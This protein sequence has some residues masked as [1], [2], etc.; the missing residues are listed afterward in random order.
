[1]KWIIRNAEI[2]LWPKC[3]MNFGIIRFIHTLEIRNIFAIAKE[4]II[5]AEIHRARKED[6]NGRNQDAERISGHSD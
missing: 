6:Y 3:L 5:Q 4:K 1:M 2:Q